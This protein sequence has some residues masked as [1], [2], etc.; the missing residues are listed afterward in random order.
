MQ[1][2]ESSSGR[3]RHLREFAEPLMLYGRFLRHAWR[4]TCSLCVTAQRMLSLTVRVLVTRSLGWRCRGG[5]AFDDVTSGRPD[6][7]TS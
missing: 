3:P 4:S 7:L 1:R 2:Q 5:L 6:D